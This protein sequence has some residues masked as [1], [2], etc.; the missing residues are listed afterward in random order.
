[1][2][3]VTGIES[4]PD[5]LSTRSARDRGQMHPVPELVTGDVLQISENAQA[6]AAQFRALV[7]SV[8]DSEIRQ[9]QVAQ[10]QARLNQGS[11]RVAEVVSQVAARITRFI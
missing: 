5:P 1:M 9:E 4:T 3:G 8:E 7:Q 10:A 2:I 11:H 6:A